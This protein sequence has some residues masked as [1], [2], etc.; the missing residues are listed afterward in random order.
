ML[1]GTLWTKTKL[2]QM[3]QCNNSPVTYRVGNKRLPATYWQPI[4]YLKH[5]MQSADVWYVGNHLQTVL[6]SKFE[7]DKL[8]PVQPNCFQSV[9]C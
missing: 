3:L 1:P 4:R 5:T 9:Y 2:D 8:L 6:T 7:C